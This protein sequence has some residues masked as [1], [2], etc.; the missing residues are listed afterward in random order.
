MTDEVHL[1]SRPGTVAWGRLPARGYTPVASVRDGDVVVIDTVSHEGLLE[2]QGRDPVRYFAGHGVERSDVLD[3][4]V[5]IAASVDHDPARHGPHV[6]TGPIEVV[7][8]RPGDV[9]EIETLGLTRRV[10]YGVISNRHGRGA[11]PGELPAAGA[12]R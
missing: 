5:A 7:G 3:D 4:A 12:R 1:P 2:D 8:A 10:D 6:V 9:V 11:L